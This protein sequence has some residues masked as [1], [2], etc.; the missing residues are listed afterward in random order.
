MAEDPREKHPKPPHPSQQQDP[1][2][3][4]SEMDPKPDY[5]EESYKG[6]GKLEGK[7][8]VIT[9]GPPQSTGFETRRYAGMSPSCSAVC[10]AFLRSGRRS[11]ASEINS[12][13]SNGSKRCWSRRTTR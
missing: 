13:S 8:A 11:P 4:E 6:S 10:V 1:P 9:G 2:G 5:G 3:L 12:I 7:A